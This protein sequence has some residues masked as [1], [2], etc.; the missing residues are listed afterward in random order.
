MNLIVALIAIFLIGFF[1]G[2]CFC[3]YLDVKWQQAEY[4]RKN[5]PSHPE[6]TPL[7]Y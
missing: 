2:I 1:A 3:V 7:Q 5:H 4:R 6:F